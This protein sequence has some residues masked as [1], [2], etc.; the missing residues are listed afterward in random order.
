MLEQDPKNYNAY[1]LL[2]AAHQ[3]TNPQ[4]AM[5]YLRSATK[6]GKDTSQAY[7][8][9]LK[10]CPNEEIPD[11]ARNVLKLAPYV[12]FITDFL[13]FFCYRNFHFSSKY[14]DVHRKLEFCAAIVTLINKCIS[15][16]ANEI[17]NAKDNGRVRSAYETLLQIYMNNTNIDREWLP[18]FEET[19][20]IFIGDRTITQHT[21]KFIKYLK[22]LKKQNKDE[23]L[24]KRAQEMLS[25]YPKEY[26][27]LELLCKV[28]IDNFSET[29][30]SFDVRKPVI[31]T[32]D[33]FDCIFLFLGSL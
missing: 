23:L 33:D 11:V 14:A 24:V 20:E 27:P 22:I 30:S 29:D 12:T 31:F 10:F 4:L 17:K 13:S 18:L 15:I 32:L 6:C 19:F 2:A 9:L 26:I 28:Y 8:G 21:L 3:E 1:L 25:I 5:K 7:I 16:L